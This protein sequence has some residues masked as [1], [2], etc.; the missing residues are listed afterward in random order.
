MLNKSDT[1]QSLEWL[2][3]RPSGAHSN[4]SVIDD[5]II[6]DNEFKAALEKPTHVKKELNLC[7][8]DRA[9]GARLA[10]LIAS[11]YGDKGFADQGGELEIQFTGTAGQSFGAFCIDG[12]K[13]VMSGQSND[14][15]G[16]SMSGGTI[17]VRPPAEFNEPADRN[18]IVGN[19]CLYGANGGKLFASGRAGERFAVRNSGCETVVEGTGDHACE[20]MTGGRVVILGGIGRNFGA[21]MTGGLAYVLGDQDETQFGKCVNND[22]R[23]Q[24]V[25]TDVSRKELR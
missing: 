1:Y 2:K 8:V 5:E 18:V 6:N 7:N 4:G 16:K 25:Q 17:V 13:L 14:Y 15:V 21:G 20:Y 9:V 11:I 24:R 19:T 3:K 10:G 23:F 22:V 12:M